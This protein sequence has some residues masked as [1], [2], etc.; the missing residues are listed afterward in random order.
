MT[1][2]HDADVIVVGSGFG[3][4]VAA[5]RFAQAGFSVVVLER[6]RRWR[7]GDFPRRSD[8]QDGWLWQIDQGLY[9]IRWLGGMA[10]AQ[11][12]GW[13]G[14]SL[15]YAN[16][17]ARPSDPV[18]D[19]RWP[20]HL[21]R[22]R[23]DPYYDLAAH[24]LGVSPTT[25]DPQTG[26]P[27]P[28][29]ALIEDF[30]RRGGI[31]EATIRPNL[32]VTFGEPDTWRPNAHGVPRRGCAFVGECVIGCNHGAKNSLDTT[33]LAAAETAGAVAVTDAQ[34]DRLEPRDGGYA[35]IASTPTAPG[36]ADREWVA[37]RV[38][39]AAGTIATTELLL[40]ARDVHGTLP[41]LSHR[42]G[43]DFSGNGDFLTMA[44]LRTRHDSTQPPEDLRTGPTITTTS[45]MDFPEGRQAVWF[46]VQDGAVPPA[47][48]DL[49]DTFVPG[50]R[51]L[52]WWHRVRGRDPRNTFAV[53]AMGRDSSQGA[54]R[55]DDDGDARL[56]WRTRWQS[57][58]HRSQRRVSTVLR[59]QLGTRV[60][61]PPN[62]SLL[63]R[64]ITVH[65]LG[66]VPEGSDQSS[67]VVDEAGEVHGYPGLLVMDGSRLPAAAG[68]NPSAT[69]LAVAEW[70][71]E[72]V[73]RR[74][75]RPGWRAPESDAVVPA[76]VPEDVPF[77]AMAARRAATAGDGVLF[78]ER[79]RAGDD[80]VVLTL[81]A[82]VRSLDLFLAD[83]THPIT[84]SG[85]VDVPGVAE[86]AAATGTLSLF[87]E[88]RRE[89]MAYRLT[90]GDH[91]GRDWELTGTKTVRSR[92]P[93]SLLHD[94]TTLDAQVH[95]VSAPGQAR[96]HVLT[97]RPADLARL[98]IS[99]RGQGFTRARRVRAMARFVE[100]FARSALRSPTSRAT[101]PADSAGPATQRDRT[102]RT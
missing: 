21:R 4:A 97:I 87:P 35:V 6:G 23:L 100:F 70:S 91:A 56:T 62:W 14:G 40:R 34:V 88:G 31:P 80:A 52:A 98:T 20:A 76:P 46:Q 17:F 15:A 86:E 48:R 85:T 13:G 74:S 26:R 77:A 95:Q 10:S 24:M 102:H 11:A 57:Q 3:G 12:A 68:V 47:L 5:A 92:A 64:T 55:L 18:L 19:A 27:P 82:Q 38:V 45:V 75:G 51:V 32:A 8:L 7:P 61:N 83:P 99:L 9:D 78:R 73:I 16:V 49:L 63:R 43:E 94:L 81:S 93:L 44:E 72:A 42:L 89:A 69:I 36:T 84:I 37:P 67:G 33:Y 41:D 30:M 54:L 59:R 2:H 66:G 50:Q 71:V 65:A 101:A 22:S 25:D 79:M 60:R 96:H 58:L 90:F 29:T 39:L 1:E 53:L 28:R